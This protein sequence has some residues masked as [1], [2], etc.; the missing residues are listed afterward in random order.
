MSKSSATP[1]VSAPFPSRRPI[2][3]AV[4]LPA[5]DEVRGIEA[6]LAREHEVLT[7][8][9]C[10]SEIIVVDDR[11]TAGTREAACRS[12]AR[13]ISHAVNRGH[14]AALKTG[15]L[16]TSADAVLIM[17]ADCTYRPEA[18]PRLYTLLDGADMVVGS[19]ELMS[20]GV[21]WIRRPAKWIPNCFEAF[22]SAAMCRT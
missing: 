5:Y 22:S 11:S 3:L 15:I 10:T 18:I 12:G 7:S 20:S 9:D 2:G 17:G 21:L 1:S 19:R 14:G 6:T 13:V 16:K 8:L 4:I